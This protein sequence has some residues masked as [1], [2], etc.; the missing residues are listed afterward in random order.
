MNRGLRVCSNCSNEFPPHYNECSKCGAPEWTSDL[1][2]AN[3]LDWVYDLETYPNIVT[4]LFKHV[5]SGSYE[6]FEL[7]DRKDDSKNLYSFLY[8]LHKMQSRLIGF[9]N[10][11]FDYPIVH[12]FIKSQTDYHDL[13]NKAQSIIFSDWNNRFAHLI[14]PSDVLIPQID[15]FKLNHFDN[16]AKRTGLKKLEFNMQSENIEDLPFAPGIALNDQQKDTLISYQYNDVDETEKFYFESLRAIEFREN[17]G[18]KHNRN[19]LNHDDTKI[20]KD[21]FVMKLEA[22]LPGSCYHYVNNKKTPRGTPRTSIPLNEIIFKYVQFE[23]REFQLVHEWLM[24]KTIYDTKGALEYCEV[25]AEFAKIM[26]PKLIKVHDIPPVDL[27]EENPVKLSQGVLLS[28]IKDQIEIT[29]KYRYV[30]GWKD[31]SGLNCYINDFK[32]VYG[33]GGIH[34]SIHSQTVISDNNGVIY[35]WDVASYYPNLAIVNELYPEHLS[36]DFCKVYKDFYLERKQYKKGTPEN[37][38]IKLGLNSV[39]GNSNNKYA[40]FYDPKF[41]MSITINGQLLLCM[42]AE[43]LMKIPNLKMVQINTD[44]LTVKCPHQ[45]VET[46]KDICKWWENYTCLTLESAIYERMFIRDVNNYIAEY[47][48][49]G[50]KRK[51]AYE[52]KREWHKNHSQLVVAKAVEAYLVK[53]ES[54]EKF[55]YEHENIYDFMICEKA[56]GNDELFLN[57]QELTKTVRYYCSLQGGKLI[58]VSPPPKGYEVGQWKRKSGISNDYY[59]S[60]INELKS[61]SYEPS[62]LLDS[63]GLPWDERINSKNQSKY[64]IRN[65][66]INADYSATVCNNI[67][68]ADRM[69]IDYKYYIDEAYKLIN[70]VK[71]E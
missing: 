3:P 57:D 13:Y 4:F 31:T 50:V 26:E 69:T 22:V 40:P 7:S 37:L 1:K 56:S 9:N 60:V 68:D 53:G 63:V 65:T 41:T 14:W 29:D 10:I 17:L 46:M 59:Q 23:R 36:V 19:F 6:F 43:Q 8:A 21:V 30:S 64:E 44:G 70:P 34:G 18:E 45:Y 5:G 25:S 20:G 54:V 27:P 42:L 24:N 12:R 28:K 48:G 62:Q 67:K 51:G 52:Y 66:G 32:F 38:G 47:K 49:G 15:L 2:P 11:N 35:D 71:G 55:I 16:K 39:Y 33:T 61:G 58:K